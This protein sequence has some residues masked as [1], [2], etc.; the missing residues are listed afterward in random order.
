[1]IG[2]GPTATADAIYSKSRA[3]SFPSS[4]FA[5]VALVLVGR[6]SD[7]RLE[8]RYHC[9]LSCLASAVGLVLI[10]QSAHVPALAFSA[11][12]GVSGV[13]SA[14]PVLADP[15][16]A[17]HRNGRGRRNHRQHDRRRVLGVVEDDLG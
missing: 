6:S 9:A 13:L 3:G 1:M 7:R 2:A 16:D 10:G 14:F 15:D 5:M 4:F 8:R 11:L 12:V 17:A